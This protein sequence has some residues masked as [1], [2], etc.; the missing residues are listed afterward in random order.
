[1]GKYQSANGQPGRY[2]AT[3]PTVPDGGAGA[4][5]TD[6]KGRLITS[7]SSAGGSADTAAVTSVNDGAASVTLLAANT[8]RKEAIIQ[9]VSSSILYVK[10]GATAT[11]SDYT[12]QLA[13]L[14]IVTTQYTGII[15]GIW[16][17]DST[18]AAKI[19]EL[20]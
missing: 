9:N 14:E 13:N 7:P 6:N 8:A 11:T 17:S 19:T 4:L 1:M 15:D 16:A 18:G 12:V 10:F 2:N 20:T 5:A 3:L